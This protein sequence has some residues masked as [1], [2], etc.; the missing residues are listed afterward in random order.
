MNNMRYLYQMFICVYVLTFLSCQVQAQNQ[1]DYTKFVNPF[2][3]TS[4]GGNTNPGAV[5]PWGM[6]SISPFNSFDTLNVRDGHASPYLDGRKYIS[7]FTQVNMSGTGAPD[8]GTF[9]LMPSTGELKLNQPFNTSEYINEVSKP[10][11]YSVFLNKFKV[12]VELT[13]TMRT[14]ISR[15]TFP[16]G[17]SN[18][19]I[20]LGLGLTQKEGAVIRRISDTEVDG[21]KTIGNFCGLTSVQTVYFY[22]KVSK[23]PKSVGVWDGVR[24]FPEMQREMAG[25]NIG[26]YFC[27]ETIDNEIILVKVG[28][29]YVS[30][31]NA[32][33]NA[34]TELPDF[35]FDSTYLTAQK[36]WNNELS[37]IK[38]EG[39]SG[40]D[41]IKFY[42]ALYHTLLHPNVFNDVNGEYPGYKS[43]KILKTNGKDRF[44]IFSL[45][46]TYR[47]VNPFL[48]LVYPK[49][50]S[51]MVNSL[52]SMY[53]EGGW[54]PK[55]E[56][57][58]TETGV[59]T[60]DPSLPVITD[61]YL[62][63]IR[64][65]DIQLAYKAMK[66]NATAVAPDEYNIMRP[67]LE[68]WLK[69]GFI[70]DDI[71]NQMFF[72]ANYEEML[73]TRA[74]WGSVSTSLEYCI[75]DW[76]LGQL[77]KALGKNNDY[78]LFQARSMLYK[79]NFDPS[80]NFMRA[81][82]SNGEWSEKLDT[83]DVHSGPFTEGT[84]WTYTFMVAHDIP[85]L[86]KLMGGSENFI[87]KLDD[88]FSQ[89]HFDV[90][91]EPDIA[92]PYL[93]NY[94]KG[95]EW[96]TQKQVRS[97]LTADFKNSSGGLPGNDDCGTMSTWL[98]YSMMGFYPTCPGDMNYQLVSPVFKKITIMLDDQYYPGKTFVIEAR[99]ASKDNTYIKSIKLNGKSCKKYSIS[100]QQMVNGGT[101][102]FNLNDNK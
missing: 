85:G 27:Y 59:M 29:S 75:A 11:Y 35:N 102:S 22:A 93:Y 63:G 54:L 38:V 89:N 40:D 41:Q 73:R 49:Q 97:I 92:Y 99:A 101:L 28:V 1:P 98:L 55:W 43:S 31:A 72:Y 13:T 15:Y 94:V 4:N 71:H 61:T 67:G 46:D 44:T 70:P 80:L 6:V 18:I 10:G 25:R 81:K 84:T 90:T 79:N 2:I 57:A 37:K 50:Q 12:K 7:G 88:C 47:N 53:K 34:D 14:S 87:K 58:G 56:L 3:G 42:T 33:L 39:G 82:K 24:K 51:A 19:L 60:G 96:K 83:T 62:R 30:T 16:K 65:F 95:Q 8:L 100:H 76:N 69:Y 32:K 5:M 86:I 48:S 78:K 26:A 9:C 23:A 77:A 45:W 52:V 20:N 74:V 91:N 66:H 36:A 64:D 17:K 68:D 21:F